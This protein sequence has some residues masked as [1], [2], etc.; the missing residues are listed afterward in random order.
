MTDYPQWTIAELLVR[1][2]L[3]PQLKDVFVEGSF[4]SDVLRKVFRND[5]Q[6]AVYIIDTVDVG[7]EL[8]SDHGLSTGNKQRLI[9]LSRELAEI[10]R[11]ARVRCLVDQDLDR[12][13]GELEAN[14][15]LVWTRYN[16]LELYFYE[17]SFILTL[18][19]DTAKAK[20]EDFDLLM[21]SVV[22]FLR[23]LFALR[24]AD[25]ELGLNLDWIPFDAC[26]RLDGSAI[27]FDEK[28]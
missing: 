27:E 16:S 19:V 6:Q 4:D 14:S 2:D 13:F 10:P 20:F 9:V 7:A 5:A 23:V 28:E 18:I 15:R 21:K 1:Y 11:E 26:L 22:Y 17:E 25:R 3:E 24:L 8:L 12:W